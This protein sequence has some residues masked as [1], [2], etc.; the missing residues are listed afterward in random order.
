MKFHKNAPD[1]RGQA[2]S[3]ART[4]TTW[5]QHPSRR[6]WYAEQALL[7]A[8][9]LPAAAPPLRAHPRSPHITGT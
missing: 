9:M 6:D 4:T 3:P 2:T 1:H 7:A 8:R 5:A